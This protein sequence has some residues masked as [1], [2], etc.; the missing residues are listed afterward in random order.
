MI[1]LVELRGAAVKHGTSRVLSNLDLAIE[2]GV[3]IGISGRS[4]SGKSTLARLLT[5]HAEPS[6]GTRFV[7]GGPMDQSMGAQWRGARRKLQ[8]VTQDPANS[9]VSRWT[10]REVLEEAL[11]IEP[12][13]KTEDYRELLKLVQLPK[14]SWDRKPLE[15]SGG[16]RCRLALA[17][18][19]A[20]KPAL[21]V[22]DETLSPLEGGLRK[23]IGGLLL[24]MQRIASLA[25]VVV[26]H[27]LRL[28][29]A[30]CGDWIILEQGEVAE[31]GPA[32][33]IMERPASAAAQALV[34]ASFMRRRL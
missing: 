4:G 12:G 26:S 34:E 9:F 27:D 23:E 19:L 28:L 15:L 29:Q 14:E 7:M 16:Q 22:L 5:L 20:A 25:L 2:P 21:L 31:R 13:D 24:E 3:S 11:T 17:R 32:E 30:L 6:E 33:Q 8:L 10:V 1:P 18:A